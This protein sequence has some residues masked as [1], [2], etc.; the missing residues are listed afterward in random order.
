MPTV[1]TTSAGLLANRGFVSRGVL[2]RFQNWVANLLAS[3]STLHL[4]CADLPAAPNGYIGK[5]IKI[6]YYVN[7]FMVLALQ[8]KSITVEL[9]VLQ[10]LN[11]LRP[12]L[13][14]P[15][16]YEALRVSEHVQTV[17]GARQSDAHSVGDF[18]EPDLS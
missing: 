14:V 9:V 15:L 7:F 13:K 2:G 18:E 16:A 6:L 10:V 5:V 17:L 3:M 4:H 1:K 11:H 8:W 12:Q